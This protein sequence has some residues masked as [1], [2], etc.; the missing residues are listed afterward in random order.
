MCELAKQLKT[1]NEQLKEQLKDLNEKTE[2]EASASE[3]SEVALLFPLVFI[4]VNASKPVL[5]P[6]NPFMGKN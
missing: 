3:D 6:L 2:S 5:R 1:E 4:V